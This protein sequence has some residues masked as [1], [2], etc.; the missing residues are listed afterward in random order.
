MRPAVPIMDNEKETSPERPTMAMLTLATLGVVFGDIGT[1]PLYAFGQCFRQEAG[2]S[3]AD[4]GF[5]IR[6]F[7]EHPEPPSI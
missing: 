2:H 5:R 3:V 6:K 4:H 1:S 7:C